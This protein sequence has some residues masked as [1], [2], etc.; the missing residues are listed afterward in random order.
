M[1]GPEGG[2]WP[3]ATTRLDWQTAL[4]SLTLLKQHRVYLECT[5]DEVERDTDSSRLFKP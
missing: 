3:P 2:G 4:A 1:E 5:L